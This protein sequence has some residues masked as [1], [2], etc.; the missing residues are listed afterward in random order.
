MLHIAIGGAQMGF[1]LV[2]FGSIALGDGVAGASERGAHDRLVPNVGVADQVEGV[3]AVDALIVTHL[4]AGEH[5]A[6]VLEKHV[7]DVTH[8]PR[9]LLVAH[10]APAVVE[11]RER[12]RNRSSGVVAVAADVQR[13]VD[14]QQVEV[15]A[16]SA[17]EGHLAH[18][19]VAQ[20]VA[21][22]VHEHEV[23]VEPQGELVAR[24]EVRRV[25]CA[26]W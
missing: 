6:S 15:R 20:R 2:L 17:L 7:A 5:D 10:V 13:V 9:H 24:E 23:D 19:V 22:R 21:L 1:G 14:E 16:H 3:D 12:A 26:V 8:V 11:R 4:A 18:R 25:Q